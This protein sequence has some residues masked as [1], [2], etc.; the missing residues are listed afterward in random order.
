MPPRKT[1]EIKAPECVRC[2]VCKSFTRITALPR[3]T[4][5]QRYKAQM[6]KIQEL[7][8]QHMPRCKDVADVSA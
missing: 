5:P 2:A 7:W 6:A 1:A 4:S 8:D 3:W